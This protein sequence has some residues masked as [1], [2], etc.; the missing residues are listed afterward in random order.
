MSEKYRLIT[1]MDLDGITCASLL[2]ELD[3]IDE[4]KFAHPKDMQDGVIEVTSNDIITNL[5]Y[6]PKAHMVFDH[7]SSEVERTQKSE[8]SNMINDPEAP[9]AA[10]VLYKHYGG[11]E[12]FPNVS[13]DLMVAVDKLDAAQLSEKDILNPQGWILLGI[14]MDNRTGLGRFQEFKV[15]NYELMMELIELLRTTQNPEDILKTP[16]IAERITFYNKQAEMAIEQIERCSKINKNLMV[17]DLRDEEKIYTINRFALYALHPEI[18]ISMHVMPG[19]KGVNTVFAVGKSILNRS[20]TI[21]IGSLML[22]YNGG[23]HKAA[24]TCQ[25]DNDKAEQVKEKLIK[26][27]SE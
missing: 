6:H 17:L 9:S 21:D 23:G 22:K 13:E 5:P 4:I 25:I 2:K 8:A 10:H 18:N 24:G 7:H 20:S 12:K 19:K 14:I 27:L 3:M 26:A 16:N 11:A 15:S 1:R